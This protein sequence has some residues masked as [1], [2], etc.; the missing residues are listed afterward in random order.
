MENEK[1]SKPKNK[2]CFVIGIVLLVVWVLACVLYGGKVEKA[3]AAQTVTSI[4]D[5]K[6][7]EV[8]I[9]DLNEL[10]WGA[11]LSSSNAQNYDK[12]EELVDKIVSECKYLFVRNPSGNLYDLWYTFEPLSVGTLTP[13]FADLKLYYKGGYYVQYSMNSGSPVVVSVFGCDNVE[14]S[15][16]YHSES[17]FS[18]KSFCVGSTYDFLS[19]VSSSYSDILNKTTRNNMTYPKLRQYSSSAPY[20][21]FEKLEIDNRLNKSQDFLGTNAELYTV[22]FQTSSWKYT[23]KLNNVSL[24][25]EAYTLNLKFEVEVPTSAYVAGL[26]DYFGYDSDKDKVILKRNEELIRY[27]NKDKNADFRTVVIE[28]SID[29]FPGVDG[30]IK[31][32]F[33]FTQWEYLLRSFCPELNEECNAI[34][35]RWKAVVLSF[36]HVRKITTEVITTRSDSVLY[37]GYTTNIFERGVY[38]SCMDVYT[39]VDKNFVSDDVL[40]DMISSD[41]SAAEKEYQKKLEERIKELEKELENV[42]GSLGVYDDMYEGQNLWEIVKSAGSGL[43]S[44]LTTLTFIPRALGSIFV[45]FPNEMQDI[46]GYVV[47]LSIFFIVWRL[48]KGK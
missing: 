33:N 14:R 3:E 12:P 2:V 22:F 48:F 4:L 32:D 9:Y 1:N 29:V 8:T 40:D 44:L 46:M 5:G 7:K 16:E 13:T 30:N 18:S 37:G 19:G 41:I 34:D 10:E 36:M 35:A 42:T 23:G 17:F 45:F 28:H 27:W 25:D 21:T 26:Y 31:Y 47:F 20:L 38:D 43:L 24:N 6:N 11:W 39:S 15:A